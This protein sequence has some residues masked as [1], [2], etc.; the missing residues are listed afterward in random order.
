LTF[1]GTPTQDK[2]VSN[3]HSVDPRDL[4]G[5]QEVALL[6]K[7]S[8]AAVANWASRF[9]DFPRPVA[10]LA[11]GPVFNEAEIRAWLNKR[12]AKGGNN[13]ANSTTCF[14]I[15]P[16]GDELA[17]IGHPDRIRYEEAVETWEKVIEP[18][19]VE[20]GLSPIT[21]QVFRFIRDADVVI[22][23]VTGGNA[24]VMYELGLRHTRTKV[25]IQI[26]EYGKL[27]F[28]I[29]II[30]TLRFSRTAAGLVDGR[31]KLRESLTATLDGGADP[32]TPTRLW[33]ASALE[34]V[35]S[36]S[37]SD[38]SSTMPTEIEEPGVFEL[39]AEMEAAFP[40]LTT[41]A[42]RTQRAMT[43]M[44]AL[45]ERGTAELQKDEVVKAG[46][47]GRLV[48]ANRMAA[49]LSPIA[50]EFEV[51]AEGFERQVARIDAGMTC[52]TDMVDQDP[53][54]REGI[55][56]FADTIK[57]FVTNVRYANE[58]QGGLA[59][60][61][62]GSGK[63]S[64]PMRVATRRIVDATRR[65]T[66]ALERAEVWNARLQQIVGRGVGGSNA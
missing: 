46:F 8:S 19:C 5:V 21:E 25:T 52:L 38:E 13:V 9:A 65:V 64:K 54:Q 45:A 2:L 11:A 27:P 23:D 33:N 6:A 51:V 42:Q 62:S 15:G 66:K 30:R 48:L 60:A 22:A 3:V 10:T 26:G 57:E 50:D 61:L 36:A 1:Y 28:D 39:L 47:A 14:V 37:Y 17:P 32:V 34:E 59:A 12:G 35:P 18:A 56:G 49:E 16:I 41:L 58:A 24:N 7:V 55:A 31:K 44:A 53:S 29:S 40:E 4:V 20:L 63:F 43:E